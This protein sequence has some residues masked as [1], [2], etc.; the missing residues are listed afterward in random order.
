MRARAGDVA[1]KMAIVE[2]YV[3]AV[4]EQ[5]F[6]DVDTHTKKRDD[7]CKIQANKETM[8]WARLKI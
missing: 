3:C 7:D 8:N 6:D 2:G 1:R 5:T 4:W